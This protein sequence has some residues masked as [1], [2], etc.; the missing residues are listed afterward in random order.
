MS[1]LGV[2]LNVTNGLCSSLSAQLDQYFPPFQEN[3]ERVLCSST[4]ILTYLLSI[5]FLIKR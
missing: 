1:S 3:G 2:F 5:L 4:T